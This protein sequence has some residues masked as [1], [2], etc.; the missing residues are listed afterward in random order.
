MQ[1]TSSKKNKQ[2]HGVL[3]HFANA[4]QI[5]LQRKFLT[6]TKENKIWRKD[7]RLDHLIHFIE[8][9][10][11]QLDSLISPNACFVTNIEFNTCKWCYSISQICHKRGL[12]HK[13]HMPD[14]IMGK[15]MYANVGVKRRVCVSGHGQQWQMLIKEVKSSRLHF[16]LILNFP[17]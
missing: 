17:W 12:D 10:N 6:N 8:L 4:W 1:S 15:C 7:S 9:L 2:I 11:Y 16:F 3:V 14:N 5:Y 13:W